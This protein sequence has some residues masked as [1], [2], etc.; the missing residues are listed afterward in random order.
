M[1]SHVA[2]WLAGGVLLAMGAG[3]AGGESVER[4]TVV[5]VDRAR[6]CVN[7]RPLHDGRVVDGIGLTGLLLNARLVQG[8]FDDE[9]PATR[10]QWAY[11]DGPFDADRN[12][13]EFVAAM[14]AWRAHGLDGFTI[15]LQGGSPQGYSKEQPWRNSAFTPDGQL[16]PAYMSRL[17]G[18]LD[19]ADR[20]G[21]VVILSYFYF[22]Q[23]GHFADEAAVLRATDA[24]TDWVLQRGYRNVVIELCNEADHGQYPPIL[25]PGRVVELMQRVVERSRARL[26]TPA[27]RLLVSV[28]LTGGKVPGDPLVAASDFVLLHGNGVHQSQ[29]IREMVEQ[30]R[31]RRSYRGQP[32]VFNEDDHFD[33]DKPDCNMLTALRAGAGWGY[34]D[35]RMKGE[36]HADGFQS[37]PVDWGIN[38]Q[39]KKAFFGLLKQ[40]TVA[41]GKADAAAEV[42]GVKPRAAGAG[43]GSEVTAERE[44]GGMVR[45]PAEK[46]AL[47][48]LQAGHPRLL[49]RAADF[50]A[51]RKQVE[52]DPLLAGWLAAL[53]GRAD[54]LLRQPPVE[55]ALP[56]GVRLLSVS[57][58]FLD[59]VRT[60]GMVYR[61]TGERS[62]A[63]RCI[64]EMLAVAAFKDW[65]PSHF[66]DTAEAAHAMAIGYDWLH[67]ELTEA[68]RAAIR[69]A[70][71]EKALKPGL[72]IYRGEGEAAWST[73]WPRAHHNW[74]QVCNGG[75]L[76]GAIAL[77][78]VEPQLAAGIVHHAVASL[79]RAIGEFGPDGACVEGPGYWAY[80][81]RYTVL[82]LAVL[83]SGLG[84]DF[85]LAGA[86][87]LAQAASFPID[88]SGPSGRTFN[89]ADARDSPI[90]E[91]EFFWLA[92]YYKAPHAAAHR[93]RQLAEGARPEAL[94]LLW[95]SD[96]TRK[97]ASARA[98]PRPMAGYYR[99]AECVSMRSAWDDPKAMWIAAKGGNNAFN[100]S[101]LDLGEFVLESGGQRFAI[102]LGPDNYNLPGYW[103]G[104]TPDGQR[105][106]YYRLRAEGHNTLVI[107]PGMQ[108]D[109]PHD[110]RAGI[111]RFHDGGAKGAF[112]LIDLT[113]AYPPT[114]RVLRGIRLLPGPVAIV[115]DEVLASAPV[116]LWWFM[117]TRAEVD[118]APDGR[119]ATLTQNGVKLY[120]RLVGAAQAKFT[121]MPAE[122]LPGSP[123]P[124]GQARNADVRK[125]AIHRPAA[126]DERWMVVFLPE[127]RTP[128]PA[129]R[130]LDEWK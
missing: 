63:D 54:A 75:L 100:H 28:S 26:D 117:H 110:A 68:D 42:P 32:I 55:H 18:I 80:A 38:A 83:Q 51:L 2:L 24:A 22:G 93:L 35:Y 99:R 44:A 66:L 95:G 3:V 98:K 56:D 97:P 49:A 27:G 65:N 39:R 23:A 84:D 79:Q 50:A 58:E 74:N 15:C 128:V 45:V 40:L 64:R 121:A 112:A 1:R 126:K 47:A 124:A 14:P 21:M 82:L 104:R 8:I 41:D 10:G 36:G 106:T 57:R 107:D 81:M 59:R 85:G 20:L 113:G 88:L 111:T 33:F 60:L 92:A 87:G 29:R 25:Q 120:A 71:V 16:K 89:F 30:V 103:S 129:L 43:A 109:Q 115:Q 127:P 61:L 4:K 86:P 77:A 9:N 12:A 116:E 53:R 91:P 34:F 125:L 67:A 130:P 7:G 108:A 37:V 78:E 11:P 101:H 48:G 105:W 5:S 114:S 118:I 76:A 90:R 69:T 96:F 46:D 123:N 122:P 94:D 6:F 52:Q 72:R 17:E 119:S 19:E 73:W 102:A 13:R 31:A 70:L 62:Y